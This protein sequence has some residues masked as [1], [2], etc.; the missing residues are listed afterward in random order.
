[1]SKHVIEIFIYQCDSCGDEV[2]VREVDDPP[3]DWKT[4]D[5]PMLCPECQE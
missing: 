3:D 1:M 5:E 4:D 2:E